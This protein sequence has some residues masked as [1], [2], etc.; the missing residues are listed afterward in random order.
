M[1]DLV[2][3]FIGIQEDDIESTINGWLTEKER[4]KE[5]VKIISISICPGKVWHNI[6]VAYR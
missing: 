2:K 1:S 5:T 3:V 6:V 4:K